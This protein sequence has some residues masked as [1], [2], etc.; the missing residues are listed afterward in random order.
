MIVKEKQSTPMRLCLPNFKHVFEKRN[1]QQNIQ[2][3]VRDHAN[4]M[5][6]TIRA[7]SRNHQLHTL[8]LQSLSR[9][10]ARLKRPI[11]P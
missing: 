7:F 9:T 8:T 4:Q 6:V 3:Y 1:F 5:T 2:F 10:T 11:L